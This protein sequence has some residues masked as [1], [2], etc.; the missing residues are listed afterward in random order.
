MLFQ[1]KYSN[2][3]QTTK[4]V[5]QELIMKEKILQNIFDI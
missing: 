1:C 3:L 4:E 2:C 5:I